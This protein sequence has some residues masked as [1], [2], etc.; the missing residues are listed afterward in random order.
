MEEIKC[1]AMRSTVETQAVSAVLPKDIAS[2]K[3]KP[4]LLL[5]HGGRSIEVHNLDD[6]SV[7]LQF[8]GRRFFDFLL[9][10]ATKFNGNNEKWE[11]DRVLF[12]L[13]FYL[14]AM[15]FDSDYRNKRVYISTLFSD[16]HTLQSLVLRY[17]P[18]GSMWFGLLRYLGMVTREDIIVGNTRAIDD[19]VLVATGS[20]EDILSGK[21]CFCAWFQP[22]LLTHLSSSTLI[23]PFVWRLLARSHR[24]INPYS[25][26]KRMIWHY[27][28]N[29]GASN[30]N[31]L[32]VSTLMMC[33]P[34]AYGGTP[35]DKRR[36]F[37][38]SLSAL[39][40]PGEEEIKESSLGVWYYIYEGKPLSKKQLATKY[41]P[42]AKWLDLSVEFHINGLTDHM[43]LHKDCLID[44]DMNK[45]KGFEDA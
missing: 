40:A 5:Q 2:T 39:L 7:A 20:E 37:E 22:E 38:G 43:T 25:M 18:Q 3:N 41:V 15:G 11:N 27:S 21:A 28:S 36:G 24:G 45:V 29:R 10:L 12:S 23:T 6:V 4:P 34:S 16:A 33:C 8:S 42:Y 17:G 19:D 35:Q 44:P 31:R 26:A 13:D 14:E 32:R 30:Q 9:T 1:V